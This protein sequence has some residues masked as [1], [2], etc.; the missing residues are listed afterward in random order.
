[1]V[2]PL[3]SLAT[4]IKFLCEESCNYDCFLSVRSAFFLNIPCCC[5]PVRCRRA[6]QPLRASLPCAGAAWP[7]WRAR[8]SPSTQLARAAPVTTH[9]GSSLRRVMVAQEIVCR[10][11]CFSWRAVARR[12]ARGSSGADAPSTFGGVSKS[13]RSRQWRPGPHQAH[14]PHQYLWSPPMVHGSPLHSRSG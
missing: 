7:R 2:W 5:P 13:A 8:R 6:P 12:A 10:C 11:S 14:Q 4:P 1:M 3:Y 9:A